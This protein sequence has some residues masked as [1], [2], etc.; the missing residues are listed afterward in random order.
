[1]AERLW[2]MTQAQA[3]DGK[4]LSCLHMGKPA[5]VRIPLLSTLIFWLLESDAIDD[6]KYDEKP[7]KLFFSAWPGI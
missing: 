6:I 4:H 1:M 3:Y 5:W 7:A 2:R